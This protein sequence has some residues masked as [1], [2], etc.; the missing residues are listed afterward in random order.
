MWGA[1]LTL[2]NAPTWGNNPLP[3][4]QEKEFANEWRA[5]G[6]ASDRRTR[7]EE[8]ARG[9]SPPPKL[10]AEDLFSEGCTRK[11]TKPVYR[12]KNDITDKVEE[13]MSSSVEHY[14]TGRFSASRRQSNLSP[15][16]QLEID[17]ACSSSKKP[18]CI[19]SSKC[20]HD[21]GETS[22]NEE[23]DTSEDE[24]ESTIEEA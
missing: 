3:D 24:E 22:S 12:D 10:D 11:R 2:R 19:W 21:E 6:R 5:K 23:E 8:I 9:N 15:P 20:H 17:D 18:S 13:R 16:A 14:T 7:D 1:S 4:E